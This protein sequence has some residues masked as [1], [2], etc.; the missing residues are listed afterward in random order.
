[1]Q[2]EYGTDSVTVQTSN[3]GWA[4]GARDCAVEKPKPQMA[5]L[6]SSSL[7]DHLSHYILK[8][9]EQ[10]YI[11]SS[12]P[13]L[14]SHQ[15]TSDGPYRWASYRGS[16]VGWARKCD[17]AQIPVAPNLTLVSRSSAIFERHPKLLRP[18]RPIW[19]NWKFMKLKD[20]VKTMLSRSLISW[21]VTPPTH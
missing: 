18:P 4:R 13:H 5:H 16:S 10:Y 11:L 17:Y 2:P 7:A 21:I 6:P 14:S 3:C 8:R 12:F 1:M 20:I 19:L 15:T 9:L